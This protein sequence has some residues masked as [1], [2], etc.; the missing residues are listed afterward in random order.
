MTT[1]VDK[2]DTEGG[3]TNSPS[4]TQKAPK[5]HRRWCFTLN[6]PEV[7][8]VDRL[9]YILPDHCQAYIFSLEKGASGT[10]HYQGY[11]EFKN[12]KTLGGCVK[13]IPRAHF[14]VAKGTRDD[15][16]KYCSKA[17]LQGP[18]RH[19]LPEPVEDPINQMRPWQ[20]EAVEIYKSKPDN[21]TIHWYW[22]ESGGIGKTSLAKHLCL[23]GDCLFVSGKASDVKYAVAEWVNSGKPLKA[24][25]FG[26]PRCREG[27]V[28]YAA[29]EEVKDGIFFNNK[30]EAKM[31]IFP[32]VHVFVFANFAPNLHNLSLDRWTVHDLNQ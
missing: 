32:A 4:V 8:K 30:Y 10:Q 14:E 12:G 11:L 16:I 19:G 13:L 31:V 29:L 3:N 20:A 25:I 1:E 7:D 28:D 9:L 18:W 26:L 2:V 24:V 27:Y 21:R 22:E 5:Q 23:K 17:P 15:N 6:N